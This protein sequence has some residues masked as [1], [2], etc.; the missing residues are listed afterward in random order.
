M[1]APQTTIATI[2]SSQQWLTAADIKAQV[3][4]IQEVMKETMIEGTH[5]G[6]IPG[7]EEPTLYK[8]GAEKLCVV[9]RIADSYVVEDLS[10]NDRGDA[11]RLIR[12]RV[13]CIG[14]HQ[15]SRIVLGEGMGEASSGEQKWK[16]RRAARA[17]FDETLENLRRI[18]HGEWREKGTGEIKK[19]ETYQVRTDALNLANT[20]LK[21]AVKRA[22]VAMVLNVTAASDIFTQDLEDFDA[23]HPARDRG[24]AGDKAST[25]KGG[26]KKPPQQP[27]AKGEKEIEQPPKPTAAEGKALVAPEFVIAL[28]AKAT[29]ATISEAELLKTFKRTSFDGLTLAEGS[30][31]M[32]W[33]KNPTEAPSFALS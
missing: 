20:V 12:Y 22:K 21:I 3:R 14:T 25:R 4:L 2:A 17:E 11:E 26:P 1:N 32:Q 10:E 23:D 28:K 6:I 27:Q 33:L 30:A 24:D 7:T 5:F 13:R 31:M 9:F 8:A 29:A 15:A 18:K 16:W 19:S